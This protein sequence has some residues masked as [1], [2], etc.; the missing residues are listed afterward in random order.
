MNNFQT[1]PAGGN[2]LGAAGNP[3][4]SNPLFG[5]SP[6]T[7]IIEPPCQCLR[8]EADI[9]PMLVRLAHSTSTTMDRLDAG[10]QSSDLVEWTGPAAIYFREHLQLLARESALLRDHVDGLV[11]LGGTG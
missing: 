11:R 7:D 10:R 6:I 8:V 4:F 2:T 1:L 9:G 5:H 3:I